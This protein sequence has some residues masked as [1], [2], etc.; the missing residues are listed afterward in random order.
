MYG[1]GE[2]V[3]NYLHNCITKFEGIT[4]VQTIANVVNQFTQRYF[5]FDI[6]LLLF[7]VIDRENFFV[8]FHHGANPNVSVFQLLYDMSNTM[9]EKSIKLHNKSKDKS[10]K[11]S[12]AIYYRMLWSK[13]MCYGDKPLV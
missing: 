4:D 5:W 2:T 3:N 10:K 8:Q 11:I 6:I 7:C 12:S 9:L 13:Y 1:R